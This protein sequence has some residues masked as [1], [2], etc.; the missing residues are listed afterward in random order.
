[1]K[2]R[3]LFAA[4][5]AGALAVSAMAIS[6]FAYADGEAYLSINNG[7]WT[8]YE[9]T[10]QTVTVDKDGTYT[11]S[12]TAAEEVLNLAPFQALQIENGETFN[13][14]TYVVTIDKIVIDGTEV[15][16]A[17]PCYTCSADGAGKTTR[18]NIYNE[19]NNPDWKVDENGFCDCRIANEADKDTATARLI[20]ADYIGNADAGLT[21][22]EVTFTV[23]G[24]TAAEEPK[25]EE[26][27]TE[28]PQNTNPPAGAAA[29]LALAGIAVAGAALVATKRK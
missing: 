19:W 26:P 4:L 20:P 22:I 15:A 5:A 8:D 11:V 9:K 24:L 17:G 13:N 16:L 10:E 6:A 23:S 12:M 3:R 1:M 21:S 29:G 2:L 27:K 28:E 7:D 25:T 18:V 14:N